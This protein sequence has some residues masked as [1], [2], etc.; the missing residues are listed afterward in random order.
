M[1]DRKQPIP[2]PKDQRKPPPP[3]APPHSVVALQG[4]LSTI[5][6]IIE[7]VEARCLV[8]DGP[9]TNT[10]YEMSDAELRRIYLLA[11]G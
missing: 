5:R 7:Q 6:I 9:V 2:P 3:P 11:K 1:G 4:R 10:R 8:V